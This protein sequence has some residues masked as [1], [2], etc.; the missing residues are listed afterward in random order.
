MIC[1]HQYVAFINEEEFQYEERILL[2][3]DVVELSEHYNSI[4][5]TCSDSDDTK[6]IYRNILM[7]VPQLRDVDQL[8]DTEK[9]SVIILIFDSLSKQMF[10]R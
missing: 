5:V 7:Y 4:Y 8:E 10:L 6:Q 9:Y 1:Y 2:D 3:S